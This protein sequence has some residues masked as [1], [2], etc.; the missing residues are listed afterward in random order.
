M[1]PTRRIIHEICTNKSEAF[2]G[3]GRHTA[4]DFLYFAATFPGTPAY[5]ICR[6]SERYQKF[7]DLIHKYQSQFSSPEFHRLVSTSPNTNN[8]FA[9]NENSNTVYMQ[10][11]IQVFRRTKALV[12]KELYDEYQAQGLLDANHIIGTFCFGLYVTLTN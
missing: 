10:A 5:I 11:Y 12:P 6:D 3:F 9:F 8:P 4:N 1:P 7:K 2:S